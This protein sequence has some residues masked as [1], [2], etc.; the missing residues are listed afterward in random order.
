MTAPQVSALLGIEE[1]LKGQQMAALANKMVL[2][3]IPDFLQLD[4]SHPLVA[5]IQLNEQVQLS[6]GK[7][8]AIKPIERMLLNSFN[9]QNTTLSV[10]QKGNLIKKNLYHLLVPLMKEGVLKKVVT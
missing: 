3:D 9:G 2:I 6:D 10:V 8:I 4:K 7:T 1:N 5:A